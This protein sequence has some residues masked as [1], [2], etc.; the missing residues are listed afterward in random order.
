[1][2]ILSDAVQQ[3]LRQRF[4]SELTGRVRVSLFTQRGGLIV[5]R[6]ASAPL[7]GLRHTHLTLLP[8]GGPGGSSNGYR[9]R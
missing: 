3:E 6:D 1:M 4:E 9:E 5:V 2:P 8:D 7:A